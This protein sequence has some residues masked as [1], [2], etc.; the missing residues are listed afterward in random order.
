MRKS[1][2]IL[3]VV[4]AM[5]MGLLLF[6][7][8]APVSDRAALLDPA[9]FAP[10]EYVEL[11]PDLKNYSPQALRD[12]WITYGIHEGRSG[13]YLF[14]AREYLATYGDLARA[15][16]TS[17]FLPALRH[18]L[19]HG[20]GEGRLGR[21]ILHPL[22]FDGQDYLQY[23]PDL[24]ALGVDPEADWLK[25]HWVRYGAAEGRRASADFSS[26]E[27]L[28]RYA[29]LARAYGAAGYLNATLHYALSGIR[30]GRIG[31]ST[32]GDENSSSLTLT[33]PP[34]NSQIKGRA[35]NN[36][37]RLIIASFPGDSSTHQ[38]QSMFSSFFESKNPLFSGLDTIRAEVENMQRKA[39]YRLNQMEEIGLSVATTQ[40]SLL[41]TYDSRSAA[42]LEAAKEKEL[43]DRSIREGYMAYTWS[44]NVAA[45]M[46][47][48]P[49]GQTSLTSLARATG[50]L[51]DSSSAEVVNMIKKL[52]AYIEKNGGMNSN[53]SL[54]VIANPYTS[55][56]APRNYMRIGAQMSIQVA[57][58]YVDAENIIPGDLGLTLLTGQG[59]FAGGITI[60][61]F[62][63]D[64]DP[65]F[66]NYYE[67]VNHENG[68]AGLAALGSIAAAEL[69]RN[70]NDA[71]ARELQSVIS[72][73]GI[74]ELGVTSQSAGSV[75][76]VALP[77]EL[78]NLAADGSPQFPV[79]ATEVLSFLDAG[80]LNEAQLREM[81]IDF[82]VSASEADQYIEGLKRS[83][84]RQYMMNVIESNS[85]RLT[86]PYMMEL[87]HT[88]GV[89]K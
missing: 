33:A 82:G 40:G 78:Q 58:P 76:S 4:I 48:E 3:A 22:I 56:G 16:G 30:E 85:Q 65:D 79:I 2:N 52:N 27:Y 41:E 72:S 89:R 8:A 28:A 88:Y 67:T 21:A 60:S 83:P 43:Y 37:Q 66:K 87:L 34:L 73:L 61:T 14:S 9:V 29:D 59:D 6:Q 55:S 39:W 77:K 70:P 81:V 42:V 45:Q 38:L 35:S 18:Y 68:H 36:S 7:N 54:G 47:R 49:T 50:I 5:T 46:M 25:F 63:N 12:H 51:S 75:F 53:P 69:Q 62:D 26:S 24:A 74:S 86:P 57:I 84:T 20:R 13:A 15:F 80:P 31:A 10:A 1:A 64:N 44:R 17:G 11:N 19:A 23:N 32:G 71:R